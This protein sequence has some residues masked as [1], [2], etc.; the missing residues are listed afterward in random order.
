MSEKY[1]RQ[2]VTVTVL[3]NNPI[4]FNNLAELGEMIE[5]CECSGEVSEGPSEELTKEQMTEA[6]IAQGS[7]PGFLIMDF[8]DDDG[9]QTEE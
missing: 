1:Y 6:L 3:S 9:D 7:D 8:S 5:S 4:Q 2:V